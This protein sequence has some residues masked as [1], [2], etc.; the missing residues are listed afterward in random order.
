M[1][2]DPLVLNTLQEKLAALP[3]P[4][5]KPA[6]TEEGENAKQR[7]ELLAHIQFQETQAVPDMMII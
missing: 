6:N 7:R 3:K 4:K 5:A 2:Q 1:E